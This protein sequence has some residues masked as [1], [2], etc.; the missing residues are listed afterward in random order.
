MPIQVA[1]CGGGNTAHFAA[2]VISSNPEYIVN[3]FTRR[4]QLWNKNLVAVTKGSS[5]EKR[6]DIRGN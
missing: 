5:W 2:S 4:P 3:V 1:I 6:G